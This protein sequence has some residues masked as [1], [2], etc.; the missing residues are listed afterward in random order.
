MIMLLSHLCAA[1]PL[2]KGGAVQSAVVI[3]PTSSLTDEKLLQNTESLGQGFFL[4][5]TT[6]PTAALELHAA[7]KNNPDIRSVWPDVIIPHTKHFDDPLYAGQW[8][9]DTLGMISI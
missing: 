1:A 5:H 8:Y 7:L 6:S 9:L 3:E 2:Y 4:K